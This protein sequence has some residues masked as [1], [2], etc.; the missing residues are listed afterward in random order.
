MRQE[1]L[2]RSLDA[3]AEG[4]AGR[5]HWHQA[6]LGVAALRQRIGPDTT[7]LQYHVGADATVIAVLGPEDVQVVRLPAGRW[8]VDRLMRRVA[9]QF[10]RPT[11]VFDA[12]G[13]AAEALVGRAERVL[14]EAFELLVAPVLDRI[15][16]RRLAV[17]PHG[18]LH[19]L[20]F[21]ALAPAGG[22]PLF[23]RFDVITA[24]SA[25]ILAHCLGL[26]RD[27]GQGVAV[28]GVPDDQAPGM[29]QEA[30]RVAEVHG[31]PRVYVAEEATRRRFLDALGTARIVHLASHGAF[32][33]EDPLRSGVRLGDGWL[34]TADLYGATVEADLIVLA[35]CVTGL[36]GV[37]EAD[38]PMG[39][40]R[41]FLQAGARSILNTLWHV[42]DGP[43]ALCME[44][45]H[46][47]LAEDQ[48]VAEA[49]RTAILHVRA[50]YPH[51]AHWA[52]FALV[53]AGLEP[54]PCEA[55]L[56]A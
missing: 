27:R 12:Y 51:P 22:E 36:A 40:V 13:G 44:T 1:R 43:A 10:D 52:P 28:F 41:G 25:S 42:A 17:I 30:R 2:R 39:L 37:R 24:P 48:P 46:R 14:R 26:P 34:R 18:P 21:H 54:A 38:E 33:S 16:T 15:R 56:M 23:A 7:V 50:A 4:E 8:H 53:G 55:G 45:L 19:A 20:P 29:G 35:G 32:D 3:L 49:L 31:S 9:F 47:G 5:T 11:V 6:P